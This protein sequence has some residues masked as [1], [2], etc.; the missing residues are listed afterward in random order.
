VPKPKKCT[1]QGVHLLVYYLKKV[2]IVL[3]AEIS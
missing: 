3:T 2:F 1:K